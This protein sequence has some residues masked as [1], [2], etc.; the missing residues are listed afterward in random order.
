L[1]QYRIFELQK[2]HK[3]MAAAKETV[4]AA[5]K[6][7]ISFIN[8]SPSP[9]H[10]VHE[11]RQR[12]LAAGFKELKET[13]HWDLKPLDKCFV[14]RNQSALIAFV[15]G[16]QFKPGN[17]FTMIGTHTDSPCLKVK[18]IS[19]REKH[20]YIQVGV[21]CYGGGIWHTWFDRDLKIA[22]RV[23][24]KNGT[25]IEHRLVHIDR[26]IL[27]VPNIA[28]HLQREMNDKFEFNK[29]NQLAP[30]LATSTIEQ[31]E[32]QTPSAAVQGTENANQASKHPRL[33]V[34]LLCDELKVSASEILDFELCLADATPS[35][36][37]GAFEEFIFSGRLDN[38]H[39]TYCAVTG[40]IKSCES[41]KS[42]SE[43]TNI[44]MISLFDNEEIG[45]TSAQ[46]AD[47][48]LQEYIMR[49][50]AVST[51]NLTAFEESISK[52]F[53]MSADMAHAVHPNYA[54]KHEEQHRP[55]LHKGVV[56]KFNANQRYATTALTASIVR[57]VAAICDVP[58]QDYVVRNDSPC[59]S[60][61]GPIL[62]AK[63]GLS[64][65]D[66]GCAQLSMHSI[67]EM[68]CTTSVSH[69]TTLFQSFFENYPRL[70]SG[71]KIVS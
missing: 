12:L 18:P 36:L 7:F 58:I 61:I 17:G 50:L 11:S 5:A 32:M 22:G 47:T 44:R 15:I 39:S 27:R 64:T 43:D 20:G 51:S 38:L 10:A 25:S 52:S 35:T 49:R 14:T 30:V 33:L 59:G 55:G 66:I 2:I 9:F 42:V 46:G 34:K 16:G 1:Q 40:L 48:S 56:I 65:V 60:T 21:E 53:L 54:E 68:C 28:I 57:Q 24:V 8:K 37:G 6:E 4:M 41:E 63:L 23:L 19:R 70:F 45:S 3:K 29:E 31:L 67:R 62:S 71:M 69:A 13:E 26:P